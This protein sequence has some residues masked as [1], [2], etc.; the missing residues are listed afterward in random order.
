MQEQPQF[1][2]SD[3]TPEEKEYLKEFKEVIADGDIT[4]RERRLLNKIRAQFGIS[5]ERGEEL[6]AMIMQP[7]LTPEEQEYLSE[8]KEIIA[9]GQ[10]SERERRF[11]EKLRKANGISEERAAEI[12]NN[13]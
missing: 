13:I 1:L 12:E 7:S 2:Q 11:L 8:Y 9:E 4:E 3:L 5:V 10:V 6:E